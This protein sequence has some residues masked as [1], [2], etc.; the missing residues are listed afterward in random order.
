MTSFSYFY[1]S[2]ISVQLIVRL[3]SSKNFQL[4]EKISAFTKLCP[5]MNNLFLLVFELYFFKYL[6]VKPLTYILH[7]I[8]NIFVL[9]SLTSQRK[10]SAMDVFIIY[11]YF[12]VLVWSCWRSRVIDIFWVSVYTRTL[13]FLVYLSYLIFVLIAIMDSQRKWQLLIT[14]LIQLPHYC[15]LRHD[16]SFY[17]FKQ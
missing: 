15:I 5:S 1:H 16:M 8:T 13:L 7:S 2:C 6:I 11:F 4:Y 14:A 10:K 3:K 9:K 17:F 12:Q